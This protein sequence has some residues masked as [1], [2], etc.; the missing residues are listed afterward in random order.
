MSFSYE[1]DDDQ[2]FDGFY[3]NL[4]QQARGIDPL[5][6]SMFSF[7]R[8]KTDFFAGPPGSQDGTLVAVEKATQILQKHA[9]LY[10]EQQSKKKINKAKNTKSKESQKIIDNKEIPTKT[11]TQSNDSDVIEME[12]DGVFDVSSDTEIVTNQAQEVVDSAKEQE[13]VQEQAKEEEPRGKPP[14][15]NGGTV[16]D[17]YV[18]TQTLEE[19]QMTVPVPPNTRGRDLDVVMRKQHIKVALTHPQRQVLIDAPLVKPII[20]D[21]SFWTVEDNERLVINLQ[22]LHQ[23]EWWEGVCQGDPTINVRDI[24]PETSKLG[25]LDGETRRT[26]E[27]M[28]YDQRQKSI[29]RPTSD[30]EHKQA[31]LERFKKQHPELDFSN[32]KIE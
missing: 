10:R 17:K 18:W 23:M 4:I 9:N 26:V 7:L 27:K 24:Q 32:A 12:T 3:L 19:I 2:R 1:N 21:D 25:D 15:G 31:M 6:D 28:M 5:L 8:R 22:K 13:P 14:V 20:S 16:P 11:A 29:G 30:E